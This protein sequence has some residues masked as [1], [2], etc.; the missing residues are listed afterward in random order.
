MWEVRGRRF[1]VEGVVVVFEEVV[2]E[3]E[4]DDDEEEEGGEDLL[5]FFDFG[6]RADVF[7]GG[8]DVSDEDESS[9]ELWRC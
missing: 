5:T 2:V 7:G 9:T 4:G 3:E 1:V 8:G 6:E